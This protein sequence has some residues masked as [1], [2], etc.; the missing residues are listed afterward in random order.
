MCEKEV[1]GAQRVV[2]KRF[3]VV[4]AVMTGFSTWGCSRSYHTVCREQSG[5]GKRQGGCVCVRACKHSPNLLRGVACSFTAR[6]IKGC[7]FSVKI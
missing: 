5:G 2:L 7:G 3:P 6:K 1:R 4:V